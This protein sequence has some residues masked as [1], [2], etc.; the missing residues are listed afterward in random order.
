MKTTI[1]IAAKRAIL[2]FTLLLGF[3]IQLV[4]AKSPENSSPV[5]NTPGLFTLAPVTPKEATFNDVLPEKA[6]AMVSLAPIMPKEATFNDYDSSNEIS[7]ELL[8]KLAPVTPSEADFNDISP[9]TDIDINIVKFRVPME[10]NL[11]D[12]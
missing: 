9:E 1:N 5:K 11:S 2:I 12:F 8:K 3:Q 7:S 6:Q 10:A 4:M